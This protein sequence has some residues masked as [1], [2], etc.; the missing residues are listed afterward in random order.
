MNHA[1]FRLAVLLSIPLIL[2]AQD[3]SAFPKQLD[4]DGFREVLV[5]VDSI[6]ISGQPEQASFEKLKAL[7]VTTVI[8]L[9]TDREMNN[10]EYVPF[11][12]QQVVESLDMNYVHIPLGGDDHPYTRA[13][14]SAFAD[15]LAAAPGRVLLHCTVAWRASHM[16]AAYLIAYQNFPPEKAIEYAKAINFGDLPLEGLLGRKLQIGF[17]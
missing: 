1:S 14:L 5:Q 10:R 17:K 15:T 11:D 12:E 3:Y 6:Y 9:R 16:W 4:A 7:G 13:A 8:N 2:S